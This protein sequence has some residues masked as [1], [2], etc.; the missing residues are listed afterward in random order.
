MALE[1][2]DLFDDLFGGEE[3]TFATFSSNNS[4]PFQE[5]GSP[6]SGHGGSPL[7]MSSSSSP[8]AT[9]AWDENDEFWGSILDDIPSELIEDDPPLMVSPVVHQS[10]L[11]DESLVWTANGMNPQ[12]P[13]FNEPDN[14]MINNIKLDTSM[15]IEMS[16]VS[17]QPTVSMNMINTPTPVSVT[18]QQ[19]IQPKTTCN[20]P[21]ILKPLSVMKGNAGIINTNTTTSHIKIGKN[22]FAIIKG[23]NALNN[24]NQ[25]KT[26]VKLENILNNFK[27]EQQKKI[28]ENRFNL[29]DHDY[30]DDEYIDVCGTTGVSKGMG[31]NLILTDEE[32]RLL[33]IESVSIPEGVGLTKDEEKVLKKV[34]RKIKN[35]QSAMESRRRR[36]EYIGNLE[37]R[38]KHCTDMNSGLKKKVDQ[39]SNEN[40]SLITQLKQLQSLV[41]TSVQQSKKAQT[42]TCL[43]VLLLSFAL[44]FLPF[45]PMHY[46]NDKSTNGNHLSTEA[47]T[48]ANMFRSRTLLGTPDNTD[49]EYH[50]NESDISNFPST[51]GDLNNN[52]FDDETRE[53][54]E[55]LITTEDN[56]LSKTKIESLIK[57]NNVVI[58][59]D[60][61]SKHQDV[62]I[63]E[64]DERELRNRL[65]KDEI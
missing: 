38:V 25:N 26:T 40:K 16:N 53:R 14:K 63:V 27:S 56:E 30:A 24:F 45:N 51:S 36:K 29:D 54:I 64:I 34:R 28:E 22:I 10:P 41:A 6:D 33:E 1:H 11:M 65:R 52:T 12:L 2:L 37:K 47:P 58:S 35:K 7:T 44:F 59:S 21:I 55:N 13:M 43:A 23:N 62:N 48:A 3:D 20:T 8:E 31:P 39:L 46:G 17:T 15:D 60:F 5:S 50:D 57:R 9:S 19:N 4:S 49:Y 42:G 32:K 18:L 61:T